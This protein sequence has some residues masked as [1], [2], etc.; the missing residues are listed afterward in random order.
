MADARFFYNSGARTLADIVQI[1]GAILH[2][3]EDA[4][5][6]IADVAPLERAGEADVTFLDNM[7]YV[8]SFVTASAGA[9]F[10]REKMVE[11]A[12][13]SMALLLTEDPYRAYA[14]TAQLFYPYVPLSQ[15]ISSAAHI[16][17]TATIGA[18]CVIS[19]GAVIGAHVT[20]GA[21]CVIGA[22]A[23]LHPGIVVGD[24]SRIGALCSLS[25][26][27]I[28]QRVV[29][30][31]GVHIGQDGFGFAMSREGHVKVPQLGRVLVEDDVE[32]GAGTCID[33]G[34]GPD[35]IIGAGAKID[36]LVQIGHNVQ[37]GRG[38]IIVAQAGVAGSSRVGDGAILGGQ[39]GVS[40]HLRIGAGARIAAKSGVIQDVPTGA[41]M[42]GIPAVP[43]HDWHRQSVTLAKLAKRKA[44]TH[45]E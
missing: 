40:G 8:D 14:L 31:R 15:D 36:N 4:H 26:C 22:N 34:T 33:R 35:T 44:A 16:D 39:V 5:R 3:T 23:V 24:D 29:L 32:I 28:G 41:S 18:G 13:P 27:L 43:V 9:C 17:P 25:H 21:G 6:V 37:I 19:P 30:H 1:T 11:K 42:G 2:R 7:K 20:I 12:P 10:V 38:A 45:Q